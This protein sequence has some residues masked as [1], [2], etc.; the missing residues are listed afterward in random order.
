[1]PFN[2]FSRQ[3]LYATHPGH[4]SFHFFVLSTTDEINA[5][6]FRAL[7]V[8]ER[9]LDRVNALPSYFYCKCIV[10][11]HYFFPPKQTETAWQIKFGKS[12]SSPITGPYTITEQKV[13]KLDN[14]Y[15]HLA[16]HHYSLYRLV[17]NKTEFRERHLNENRAQTRSR[18]KRERLTNFQTLG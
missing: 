5:N 7:K 1:M 13:Q 10:R 15:H 6:L 14:R 12:D 2:S 11:C 8:Y 16:I 18:N 9:H 17:S 4:F 3:K